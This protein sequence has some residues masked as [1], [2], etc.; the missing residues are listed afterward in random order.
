MDTKKLN[1][2]LN[3]KRPTGNAASVHNEKMI[4]L[5]KQKSN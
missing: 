2:Y 4:E 3:S 5:L 1:E